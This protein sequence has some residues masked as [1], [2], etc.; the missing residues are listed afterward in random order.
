MTIKNKD[1]TVYKLKGPNPIASKQNHWSEDEF[2]MHNMDWEEV[3][4]PDA[5]ELKKFNS[6]FDVQEESFSEPLKVDF[7]SKKKTTPE[8]P[9]ERV[10]EKPP[11]DGPKIVDKLKV[12]RNEKAKNIV[13]IWVLPA[14]IE[15]HPDEEPGRQYTI[16][17]FDK[18]LIE[19]IVIFNDSLQMVFWINVDICKCGSIIYLWRNSEGHTLRESSWWKVDRVL[20]ETQDE[21]LKQSGG[22]LHVCVP[23]EYTPDFSD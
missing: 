21:R 4:L 22:L 11:E 16:K 17:Y 13:D 7:G 2:E 23:S 3:D 5:T 1:G 9:P 19:A 15:H 18:K 10:Q 8:K 12:E 6:D 20:D 14:Q